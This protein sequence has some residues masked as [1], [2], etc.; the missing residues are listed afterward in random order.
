MQD[1]M[2]GRNTGVFDQFSQRAKEFIRSDKKRTYEEYEK[3]IRASVN[4]AV[5]TK[6]MV[7]TV[8]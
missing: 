5:K 7:L 8:W 1:D 3:T 2:W 6:Q 4:E